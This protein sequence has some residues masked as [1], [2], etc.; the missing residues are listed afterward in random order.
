MDLS[1]KELGFTP[2]KGLLVLGPAVQMVQVDVN[3][4][5]SGMEVNRLEG[6]F[7]GGGVTFQDCGAK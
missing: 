7:S 4:L 2:G 1:V 6:T 5:E 3:M